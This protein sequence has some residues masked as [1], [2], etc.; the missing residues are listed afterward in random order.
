[1]PH[2]RFTVSATFAK[3]ITSLLCGSL[4]KAQRL[5]NYDLILGYANVVQFG[6][7]RIGG[8]SGIFKGR[9]YNKG[10][11]FFSASEKEGLL[12]YFCECV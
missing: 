7:I 11:S 3:V 10:M 12:E 9:D 4:E 6:G 5:Y 1:M 2:L 8:L